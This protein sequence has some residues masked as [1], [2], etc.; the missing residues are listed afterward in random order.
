MT[1][2]EKLTTV[3]E[4][5][6]RV[7]DAGKAKAEGQCALKHFTAEFYGNGGNSHTINIPF[8]PDVITVFGY[9]P[10]LLT[11]T[12]QVFI[13][14]A[15]LRAF[16]IAGGYAVIHSTGTAMLSVMFTTKSIS[17]RYSRADN[18]DI[19]LSNI[20]TG[21][22]E[23]GSFASDIKY[24]IVAEKY[25]DKTDKELI[26]EFINGLN[27]SGTGT[28]TLSKTKVNA[29]FTDAEWNTLI[30]NKPSWTFVMF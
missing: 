10:T 17:S 3:A 1:I 15:D 22:G 18:G 26:T 4:N 12:N 14:T 23:K 21:D 6:Q 27:S 28:L 16:G 24:T 25:T 30:A 11:G 7:Y 8:E 20:S 5:Q 9:A 2:A 29:A 19:T 13:F